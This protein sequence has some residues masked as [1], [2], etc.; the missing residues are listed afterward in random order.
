[1]TEQTSSQPLYYQIVLD[2][3]ASIDNGT[4][5][6]GQKLPTE[7]ELMARYGVSRT[8]VRKA[9]QELCE[10]GATEHR[11]KRG[12]FVKSPGNK[13]SEIR[14]LSLF[15]AARE[16]GREPSAKILSVEITDATPEEAI[17]LDLNPGDSVI[18]MHRLRM[19]DN[20]PYGYGLTVFPADMFEGLNPLIFEH[21]S[22]LR[23]MQ[24][25]FHIDIAFS[26]QVLTPIFP[27]K[28]EAQLL[29]VSQRKPLLSI[30]STTHDRSGRAVKYSDLHANTDVMDFVFTWK[31]EASHASHA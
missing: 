27:T 11:G 26:S 15:D 3:Q 2:V 22:I 28:E 23:I 4:L 19:I 16:T 18:R 1:M 10:S 17:R 30:Q 31:S 12:H 5:I 24:E 7:S 21:E 29:N 13:S 20:V 25:Q 6:P 9:L 8:T 14:N